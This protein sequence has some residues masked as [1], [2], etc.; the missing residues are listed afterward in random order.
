M[1]KMIVVI[2]AGNIKYQS[3]LRKYEIIRII[4]FVVLKLLDEL[5]CLFILKSQKYRIDT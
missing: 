3:K 2:D 5:T 4:T 1:I